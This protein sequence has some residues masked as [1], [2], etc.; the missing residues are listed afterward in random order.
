[1]CGERAV[2][3]VW[4]FWVLHRA[5]VVTGNIVAA[6]SATFELRICSPGDK[7]SVLRKRVAEYLWLYTTWLFRRDC[8]SASGCAIRVTENET[9]MLVVCSQHSVAVAQHYPGFGCKN[10]RSSA[11]WRVSCLPLAVARPSRF[12]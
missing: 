10:A 11:V 8:L 3:N 6:R 5:S 12:A 2:L 7:R 1:M 4:K 9:Y